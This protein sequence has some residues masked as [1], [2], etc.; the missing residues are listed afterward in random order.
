MKSIKILA[1]ALGLLFSLSVYSGY[2]CDK[3]KTSAKS[4][5]SVDMKKTSTA[6]AKSCCTTDKKTASKS[7]C[8]TTDKKTAS[9]S[10]CCTTTKKSTKLEAKNEGTKDVK[11]AEVNPINN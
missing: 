3:H 4:E 10:E 5:C 7:E 2:A 11:T 9:K 8:C 6:D 1:I